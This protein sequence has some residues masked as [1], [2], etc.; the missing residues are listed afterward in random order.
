MFL[1]FCISLFANTLFA[2]IDYRNVDK[3]LLDSLLS[4]TSN[5]KAVWLNTDTHRLQIIYTRVLHESKNKIQLENHTY[6]L[7]DELYFYPASL[8]KLPV[9]VFT[10][11]KLNKLKSHDISLDSKISIEDNHSCQ[12]AVT[13][14]KL[15]DNFTPTLGNYIQKA[16]V[17][18]NNESYNRLYE[19]VGQEYINNRLSVLGYKKSR[20]ITRFSPC[21]STE[22]RYTNGFI[23]YNTKGERVYYQTP[24]YSKISLTPPL[25]DMKIGIAHTD[26][27]KTINLPK[28]FSYMNCLPLQDVHDFLIRL[29]YPDMFSSSLLLTS[30][31]R[32]FILKFLSAKPKE[33]LIKKIS[34]YKNYYDFYTNYLY[35]G[36]DKNGVENSS[37]KIYNI[38]GQSY[39]FLSDVAYFEDVTNGI[40]FF[41]SA[42]IY[43][44]SSGILG[45][46]GYEYDTI[47]LPFLRDLGK[48]IYNY[49][50]ELRKH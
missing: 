1:V 30:K 23:F 38:V 9:C 12:T 25:P 27:G 44:N 29:I 42:V 3:R 20:I 36:S 14:D 34:R 46:G 40:D 33:S 22:N 49:E 41:L 35:Y 43:T 28:D 24:A 18:S 39:G 10:L 13:I 32:E 15:S 11:E 37:L 6:N 7:S 45:K 48:C 17:I 47:G 2:Q 5:L 19:F 50:L 16:L 31:N 21:D 8:V 4:N 26:E